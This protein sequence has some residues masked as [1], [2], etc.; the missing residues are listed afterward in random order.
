MFIGGISF[1]QLAILVV[2]IAAVVA[3]VIIALRKFGI[4]IPDWVI[5]VF[6]IVIIAFVIILAIKLVAGMF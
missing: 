6:W 3:L 2:V 4:Q 5:Q 1:V